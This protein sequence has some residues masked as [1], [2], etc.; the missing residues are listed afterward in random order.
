[1]DDN[2][3]DRIYAIRLSLMDIYYD[4][5]KIIKSIKLNLHKYDNIINEEELNNLIIEFYKRYNIDI[6]TIN[7]NELNV[8]NNE[9]HIDTNTNNNINNI[10]H[11]IT[12]IVSNEINNYINTQNES[13]NVI[14]N[15]NLQN[16]DVGN[17]EN[18]DSDSENDDSDSDDSEIDD[19]NETVFSFATTITSNNNASNITTNISNSISNQLGDSEVFLNIFNSLINNIG[20]NEETYEDIKVTL[21]KEDI[22]LLKE[23]K[24]EPLEKKEKCTICLESFDENQDIIE[25]DCKHK[26][27][28]NCIMEWLDKY[29]YKCPICRKEIGK[30]KYHI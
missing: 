10:I 24:Y 7:L 25:L 17:S 2:L 12:N 23:Y 20:S 28:K 16:Q 18:D 4:E 30:P 14:F 22:S 3:F 15:S 13:N 8:I 29:D 9:S 21:D 1:M 26:F 19:V 27:H 11:E 6:T 5:K